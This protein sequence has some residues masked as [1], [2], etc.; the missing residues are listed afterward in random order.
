[1]HEHGEIV[2]LEELEPFVVIVSGITSGGTRFVN[3]AGIYPT[4]KQADSAAASLRESKEYQSAQRE[5]ALKIHVRPGTV[6]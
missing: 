4:F 5:H 3:V 1:M 2:V 6:S